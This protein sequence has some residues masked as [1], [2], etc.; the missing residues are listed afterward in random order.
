[1]AEPSCDITA[2]RV[3]EELAGIA[4]ADFTD[5]VQV[6][7][8]GVMVAPSRSLTKA[9]RAAVAS[10]KDTGKG[11][12]LKLYDKQ[13]ALELLAKHLGLFDREDE[14][15]PVRVELAAPLDEWAE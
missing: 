9:Q 13:R 14:P 11:V 8:G 3:L 6:E 10:I 5:F 7:E 1:M 4:F 2:Q 15:E 12:E